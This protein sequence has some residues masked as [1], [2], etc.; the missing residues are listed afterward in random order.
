MIHLF[1][2]RQPH[3]RRAQSDRTGRLPVPNAATKALFL[4]AA[5]LIAVTDR[6][7]SASFG[8]ASKVFL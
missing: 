3:L 8:V 7:S 4:A 6:P 1:C 2:L 5:M